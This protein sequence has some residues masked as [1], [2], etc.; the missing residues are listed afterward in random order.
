MNI[1]VMVSGGR[2]DR[3]PID[4]QDYMVTELLMRKAQKRSEPADFGIIEFM[5]C[6]K[7]SNAVHKAL[8]CML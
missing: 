2:T 8:G 6:T 4:G 7:P 3:S 5:G 1:F